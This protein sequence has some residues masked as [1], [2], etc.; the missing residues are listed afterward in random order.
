MGHHHHKSNKA[1]EGDPDDGH[2]RGMPRRPD[3]RQAERRTE[4]DRREAGLPDDAGKDD[5]TRYAEE[6]AEVEREADRGD[7]PRNAASRK[8]RTPFP[9]SDYEE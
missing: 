4:E 9:P 1:V 3:Q 6:R 7:L 8:N 5:A 2:G